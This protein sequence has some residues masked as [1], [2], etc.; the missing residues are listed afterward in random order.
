MTTRERWIVYPLLFL[1]IGLALRSGVILKEMERRGSLE[2]T[3][4]KAMES[5]RKAAGNAIQTNTILASDGRFEKL[6]CNQLVC[7]SVTVIGPKKKPVVLIGVDSENHD[8]VIE[9]LSA[10]GV[11]QTLLKST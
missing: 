1:A 11:Q 3:R 2:E 8:G 6:F 10:A 4:W 7:S 9:T 5:Q